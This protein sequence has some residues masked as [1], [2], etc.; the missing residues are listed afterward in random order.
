MN[1]LLFTIVATVA[2][3]LH[4]L[5]VPAADWNGYGSVRAATFE[6][7]IDNPA[8]SDKKDFSPALQGNS[9][10]GANVKTS[11]ELD[12][13]FEYG[14][15][16]GNV[17][18]RKLYGEWNHGTGRFL[19]GQTYAPMNFFYSNQVYG[20]DNNLNAQGVVYSGRE[21]MLLM[22]FGMFRIALVEPN[23]NDLGTGYISEVDFPAVEASYIFML[24]SLTLELA[25][26]YNS[27]KLVND[28]V[29]Y[30]I[31]SYVIAAGALFKYGR[32][33]FNGAAFMGENAGNLIAISVDGDNVW[34]DGFA[35]ISGARVLDNDCLGFGLVTGYKLSDMF[36]FEIGYG[37]AET[38]LD[39]A[40]SEDDVAAYY[41]NVTVNLA[42]GIFFVPEVGHFNGRETTDKETTYYGAKWQINF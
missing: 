39:S 27:Y 30:D 41:A 6:A 7:Q 17:D 37:Y 25:G 3:I 33:F 42:P 11:D 40:D 8:G 12:G 26:G 2:F 22:T 13:S 10:I 18:L 36:T 29:S 14:T 20:D 5:P 34:D 1:I 15:S 24:D 32:A 23:S 16:G 31:D 4:A 19:V 28:D 9:R 21:P 38:E 35:S